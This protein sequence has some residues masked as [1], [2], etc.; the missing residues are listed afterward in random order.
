[1]AVVNRII[2]LSNPLS[3]IRS[4]WQYRYLIVQM[5]RRDL[6]QRYKGAY[7]G[8]FWAIFQPM[9]ML[10]IYTFVFSIV[11]QA[12]WRPEVEKLPVGEF[13]VILFA[14]LIPFNFF[15]EVINRSPGLILSSPNYVKKVVFPLEVLVVVAVG[16]ALLT[17]LITLGILFIAILLV[18]HAIPPFIIFLPLAYLPLMLLIL[19][20]AWFLSSVG[21]YIR[22]VGQVVSVVTQVLFFMTPIFFPETSVPEELHFVVAINPLSAVVTNFRK[23]LL[24]NEMIDLT[25]WGIWLVITFFVAILGYV[26]FMGTKK[27]FA[28][29]L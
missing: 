8:L 17:S 23:L 21:V 1:M 20:L 7:L 24:W 16:S 12:R 25:N 10:L 11:F 2:E 5:I 19:G 28:D 18:Y 22:D 9:L 6:G 26:W 27:G 4:V 13:A 3:V 15:S 14:G 29:V